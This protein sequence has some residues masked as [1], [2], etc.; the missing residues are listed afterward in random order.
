[1]SLISAQDHKP[2]NTAGSLVQKLYPSCRLLPHHQATTGAAD[3]EQVQWRSVC[4]MDMDVRN[5]E[6]MLQSKVVASLG[7]YLAAAR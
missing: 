4:N 1:M 2:R 6:L 3:V 5:S 7:K